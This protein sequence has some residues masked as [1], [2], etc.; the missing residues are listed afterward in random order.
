MLIKELRFRLKEII[1]MV[2]A[3]YSETSFRTLQ[4]LSKNK[5]DISTTAKRLKLTRHISEEVNRLQ[6]LLIKVTCAYGREEFKKFVSLLLI[7]LS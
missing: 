5:L 2:E 4:L 3:F 7:E 6:N 1:E